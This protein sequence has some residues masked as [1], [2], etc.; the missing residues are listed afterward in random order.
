MP[1]VS[2]EAASPALIEG[3]RT[4]TTNG[5]GRYTIVDVR[6]GD[7]TVT[8][9][10]AGFSQLKE[11]IEVPSNVT[12]PVDADMKPGSVGQTMEVESVVA[13]V[14]IDNVAHPEVLTRSDIDALPTARNAQSMGSYVPGVHLNTPDVAGSQQTEQTY[15]AAH[16]NPS[17]RDIYMLDG[18]LINVTQNDGQIQ[19]YVDNA[20]I[21]EM[22]YQT[23][24]TTADVS[25][26][27]VFTNMIPRDGGNEFHGNLFLGWVNSH[28]VGNNISPALIARGVTG[29][30]AVNELQ[31][32]DGGVGGRI[33]KDKLWFFLSGRKQ[34]SKIQS[35]GSFNPDGSPGI[36][37]SYIWNGTIRLT[38]QV[39][40]EK[41]VC[42]YM[43]AQL[44]DQNRRRSHGRGRIQRCRPG[45]LVAPA[46]TQ[47]VLH[48]AGALD[49]H[50]DAE[51]PVAS[52]RFAD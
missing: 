10:M 17:G 35:A 32:F 31:D 4:V 16:G 2:V 44:E 20:L 24:S 41:Q 12:V 18:M 51:T 29:Q 45:D 9:T 34:L 11:R 42:S 23:N 46:A 47:D 13:T 8:F 33:I 40:H 43:D 7:Y 1:G 21:Q 30:S 14:D 3:S 50:G 49:L 39:K 28:F 19:F 37:D 27:G 52:G 25:G 22:T 36:E 6:P 38:Y 26:G 15:M 5:E 48:P